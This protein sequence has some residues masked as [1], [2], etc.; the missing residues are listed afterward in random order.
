MHGIIC[1]AHERGKFNISTVT[2]PFFYLGRNKRHSW[3]NFSV[4]IPYGVSLSFCILILIR[5]K[6]CDCSCLGQ[7][8]NQRYFPRDRN[9][10]TRD[11]AL[12]HRGH[13]IGGKFLTLLRSQSRNVIRLR[14]QPWFSTYV[15]YKNVTKCSGNSFLLF[16]FTF[17]TIV[18]IQNCPN[19]YV[20]F[21]LL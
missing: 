7:E 1:Q 13:T 21:C 10:C 3:I 19:P 2:T 17:I 12:S 20:K 4:T 11:G 18:I 9:L 14:L 16:L 5:I 15:E 8:E 6:K